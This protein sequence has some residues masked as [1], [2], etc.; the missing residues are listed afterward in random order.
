MHFVKVL[1][2]VLLGLYLLVVGLAALGFNVGVIH[3]GV[4]GFVALVAGVLFIVRGVKAY[5]C[6]HSCKVDDKY[7]HK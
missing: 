3:P 4:L 7:D 5:C 6:C 1:S 2:F